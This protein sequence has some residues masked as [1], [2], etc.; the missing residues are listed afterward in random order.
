[1]SD[2]STYRAMINE[3]HTQNKSL[4]ELKEIA[5]DASKTKSDFLANM[6]HEIR[7]PINAITGMAVIARNTD[8]R[9]RIRDCLG[10]I[11]AASRQLLGLVND[12]L[13]MSKIEANKMELANEPFE[14]QYTIMNLRSIIGIRATEKKQNLE[15]VLANDLPQVVVGDDMRLSQ[16]LLNLLSNAVKFT[17]DGGNIQ[18]KLR[19]LS[20]QNGTHH[21]EAQVRDDGI[22]ISEEQ[23]RRLFNSFE[24]ADNGISKRY[25]GSGLGLVISKRIAQLMGGDIL[26]ESELGKGSCFTALFSLQEGTA[27]MLTLPE[28]C[29][30]YDFSGYT[31]LLVEDIA[32]NREIVTTLL[33]EYGIAIDCAENGKEAVDLFFA[34]PQRYSIIFMDIHMPIMNGY[35]ATE[36]IRASENPHATDVPILAMTANA[37][38]E[39]VARC[40]AAGMNSHIAKPIDIDLLL[41]KIAVLLPPRS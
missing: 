20:T 12:I 18:M 7:T 10:K 39:D 30:D 23:Q 31:A 6:S 28:E 5:E 14:L 9:D 21:F 36:I 40:Q 15:F 13:D 41:K 38:S 32:I 4:T 16:I 22:G 29:Q 1:M 37:F 2:I 27:E 3:I 24:Q 34:D 26:L 8:D 17:P 11:D 19:L 25:G 33:E 35:E